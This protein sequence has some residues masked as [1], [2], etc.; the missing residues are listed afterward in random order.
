[1]ES[2]L[3]PILKL[4]H[5]LR[6]PWDVQKYLFDLDYNPKPQLQ[7]ALS[8]IKSQT[9][10][11]LEGVF[12]SAAI[13]EHHNFEPWCLSL[14]SQDGLDHCLFLFQ[15]QQGLWGT[16]G[17]SRDFGLNGR[18]PIFRNIKSL[19]KSY[20]D[21][22]VDK[23]GRLTAW[24]VAHLDEIKC[25]WRRSKKNVWKLEKHLLEIPHHKYPTNKKHY[26]KLKMNYIKNG[27]FPPLKN[28]WRPAKLKEV[29]Y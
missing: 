14:E 21:P 28:W 4:T 7:S 23:T 17:K 20:Y 3:D 12:I 11:C 24:Q 26:E 13:L 6:S 1:M 22:Y 27:D 10:H 25:D 9:A 16:I 8:A 19:V 18:K 15:S 2:A 29:S 5:K